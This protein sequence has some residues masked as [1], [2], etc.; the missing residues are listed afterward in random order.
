MVCIECG[1]LGKTCSKKRKTY[2]L[3]KMNSQSKDGDVEKS[4]DS[5]LVSVCVG[6][7]EVFKRMRRKN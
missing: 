5:A 1:E 6:G 7:N 4:W 3:G 2:I